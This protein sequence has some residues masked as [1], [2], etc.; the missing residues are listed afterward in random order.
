M[1]RTREQGATKQTRS[2]KS[3]CQGLEGGTLLTVQA[4]P[5]LPLINKKLLNNLTISFLERDQCPS[6]W[7]GGCCTN[8][9]D[10]HHLQRKAEGRV[11]LTG[12]S[13]RPSPEYPVFGKDLSRVQYTSLQ[14]S[15]LMTTD[16]NCSLSNARWSLG[17]LNKFYRAHVHF[18]LHT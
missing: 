12:Q 1:K 3:P 18:A 15:K 4:T 14:A 2:D 13:N 7:L 11:L 16:S 5:R 6:F 17:N 8:H 9:P 10:L